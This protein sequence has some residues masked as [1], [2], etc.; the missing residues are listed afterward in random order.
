MRERSNI[1]VI[2][3]GTARIL[4][5]RQTLNKIARV[6]QAEDLPQALQ[7]LAGGEFE[8]VFAEE[9][10]HCGT[11]NDVLQSVAELYPDLPVIVM[12]SA[13]GLEQASPRWMEAIGE[14]AFDLLPSNYGDFDLLSL[15]E[16]AVSSAR[17]RALLATA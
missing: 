5:I 7:K 1:L 3:D 9:R 17:A 4:R 10:F 2:G 13:E 14:G 6:E 11:W 16:Q 12:S 15:A 8:A